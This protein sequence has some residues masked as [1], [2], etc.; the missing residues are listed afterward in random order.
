[1]VYQGF[2]DDSKDANQSKMFV[3][4]GFFGSNDDWGSLRIDW[5]RILRENEIDYFKSYE[6]NHLTGQFARF[7]TSAYPPP[8]GRQAAKGIKDALLQVIKN[9]RS[10]RGAGVA[11]LVEDFEKVCARPEAAGVFGGSP[12][13]R[14]LESVMFETV[15]MIRKGSPHN[16]VAFVH[17]D[18]SDFAT[19]HQVYL[20]F[21]K[22]NP[23]TAKRMG[24]FGA[25]SDKQHPPLQIA[26]MIANNTLEIGMKYITKG[27]PDQAKASM[28][29]NINLLGYWNE[30]Y[31]LSALKHN[32]IRVGRPIPLDLDT[33]DYG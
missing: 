15:K 30:H 25:L 9:H 33:E 17:D 11:I 32:L 21:R 29:E 31:M 20:G 13:H 16:M 27:Q 6:Y 18:E 22:L 7:R 1:M 12:Y 23:K 26:D 3:C 10:I 4:A 2:L 19:L 14:A 8:S 5:D 24:G 28:R